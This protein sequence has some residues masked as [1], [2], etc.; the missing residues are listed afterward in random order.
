MGESDKMKKKN[1]LLAVILLAA[2]LLTACG[3]HP[4]EAGVEYLQNG[5]Y[6]NAIEQFQTAI[7]KNK[8]VGDAYRGMG[9][10]KW[11]QKDYKGAL[12]AFKNAV[13]NGAFEDGTLY[14]LMGCCS[15]ELDKASDAVDYFKKAQEDEN[16]SADLTQEISYNLI[17]A[18]EQSGDYDNA[19]T[20]LKAYV[21]KYPD[22][23]KAQKD[24]D[25]WSTR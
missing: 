23:E 13:K 8:N 21:D 2:M 3:K 12:K 7:D 22:D 9:M 16:N 11:E 17:A 14:N 24:Y 1:K 19:K 6:K 25:F 4:S 5:D 18:Y 15:L 20:Q 10:A